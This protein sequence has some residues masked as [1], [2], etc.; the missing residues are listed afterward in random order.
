MKR[1]KYSCKSHYMRNV[2]SSGDKANVTKEY[3]TLLRAE[4]LSTGNMN[5]ERRVCLSNAIFKVVD[6]LEI[7]NDGVPSSTAE[8]R[9]KD[10]FCSM[11]LIYDDIKFND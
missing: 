8:K 4:K 6:E 5:Y 7:R 10:L 1:K 2:K 11:N 3:K 9:I